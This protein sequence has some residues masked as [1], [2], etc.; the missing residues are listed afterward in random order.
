MDS[1]NQAL[2]DSLMIVP[3][4]PPD[5]LEWM[6]QQNNLGYLLA[7]TAREEVSITMLAELQRRNREY[8]DGN[9]VLFRA[10][11]LHLVMQK[12]PT[13]SMTQWREPLVA[14][15]NPVLS[16]QASNLEFWT[17][18]LK[19]E[20]WDQAVKTVMESSALELSEVK[21]K[22]DSGMKEAEGNDARFPIHGITGTP[23]RPYPDLSGKEW[24]TGEE[25]D[26]LSTSEKKMEHSALS[27]M[28]QKR[29]LTACN[30][31]TSVKVLTRLARDGNVVVRGAALERLWIV[32]QNKKWL[33]AV[34]DR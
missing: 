25:Q 32:D 13:E 12:N 7:V 1:M 10:I 20:G 17:G 2:L 28:W 15:L 4:W 3:V 27:L 33:F 29:A 14:D 34:G 31:N 18:T 9:G 19:E 24:F 22:L 5:F 8:F 11:Q 6:A 30:P 21:N 26:T 16:N 23:S